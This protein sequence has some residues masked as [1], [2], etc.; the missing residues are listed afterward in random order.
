MLN[1]WFFRSSEFGYRIHENFH[2]L[3]DDAEEFGLP[4]SWWCLP[5]PYFEALAV[6]TTAPGSAWT[7]GWW[8]RPVTTHQLI[9]SNLE[10]SLEIQMESNMRETRFQEFSSRVGFSRSRGTVKAMTHT[11]FEFTFNK[12]WQ[13]FCWHVFFKAMETGNFGECLKVKV[14]VE[15]QYALTKSPRFFTFPWSSIS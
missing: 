8:W 1:S 2:F 13:L 6:A 10:K 7:L 9:R 5:N 4:I 15:V 3:Y 11:A 12:I 14:E